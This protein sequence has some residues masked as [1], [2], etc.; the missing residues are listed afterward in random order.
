MAIVTAMLLVIFGMVISFTRTNLERESISMMQTV[1]Q[2]PFQLGRPDDIP[3]EVRLPYFTVQI[4]QRGEVIA[5][6]G[7]YYDLSDE[8]FIKNV[9]NDALSVESETG[10]LKE[11][12]LRFLK[13]SGPM[14]QTIVFADTSSESAT[15]RNLIST[16][17]FIGIISFVAFLGISI[18]LSIWAVKPVDK[19]WKQQKQFVA[20]ASH[21]LKTPLTVIITNAE[22]LQDKNCSEEEKKQFSENILSMSHQMRGLTENLLELARVDNGATKMVFAPVNFSDLVYDAI[23]PFEPLY[24]EK[25]LNLYYRI[26]KDITVSGS[27][28]HL[29]QVAD[30]LLDNAMKYSFENTAVRVELSKKERF[31]VLSVKSI[32]ENIPKEELKNIFKRFYRTD[33]ARSMDGSYGLGLSIAESIISEHKGKIRAESENGENTFFVQI[34][35]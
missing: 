15:I 11:Y 6:G 34:P 17:V 21:E 25:N 23:L 18:M 8:E 20:D 12:S 33:K 28:E 3:D 7:G 35:I 13:N 32:G 5:S 30:I 2:S 4:N 22:L 31:C 14:G 27:R 10:V 29:K 24:F 26:D 9:I 1:A 16:C 19:A